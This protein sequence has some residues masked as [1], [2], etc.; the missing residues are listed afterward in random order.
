MHIKKVSKS[1]FEIYQLRMLFD[2]K[3]CNWTI[4]ITRIEKI[5]SP[6]SGPNL[7]FFLSCTP[8]QTESTPSS[9]RKKALKIILSLKKQTQ[10]LWRALL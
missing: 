4:K 8:Q 7:K 9:H 3:I 1:K 5:D 2:Y 10:R 6:P